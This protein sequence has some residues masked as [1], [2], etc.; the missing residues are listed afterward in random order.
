MRRS[1]VFFAEVFHGLA[2]LV[3][4]LSGLYFLSVRFGWL[5]SRVEGFLQGPGKETLTVWA[6]LSFLLALYFLTRGVLA[7]REAEPRVMSAGPRGPIWI[8]QGAI[9]DFILQALREEMGFADASVSLKQGR[10]GI[11]VQVRTPLPLH[12]SV[13]ELG[14][15]IQEHVKARV[16]ERI[17]V[18]VERVEV[19][20]KSVQSASAAPAAASV[21]AS[22]PAPTSS[23]AIPVRP[24]R[25]RAEA[26]AAE[27]EGEGSRAGAEAEA[28]AEAESK[29]ER[30]RS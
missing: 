1:S 15:K 4:V 9:R 29:S 30:D 6:G 17:G 24:P 18:T 26:A 16:E 11:V 20:A 5:P 27:E 12:Q 25:S 28:E 19:L 13:T 23:S 10:D 2:F 14:A 22:T 8:S 21:S 7:A 3:M